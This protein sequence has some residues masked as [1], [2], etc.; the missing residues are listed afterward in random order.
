M[1]CIIYLRVSTKEQAQTNEKEGYSISAQRKACISY[2]RNEGWEV[3]DEYVDRGESARS[4]DRPQL[5]EML[6]RIK[7]EK[8]IDAVV[9]HKLDRFSRNVEE[10]HVIRGE[11][12]RAN[13]QLISV[14]E[15]IEDTAQGRFM[16]SIYASMAQFYSDNLGAEVTKGMYEKVKQGGWPHQAPIGYKNV[17]EGTRNIAIV[18]PDPE[19]A[20]YVKQAFKL[21][22]TGN[23]SFD[24]I[25]D[26]L[27][28]KGV[29]SRHCQSGY[30]SQDTIRKML[31]NP[32]YIGM[33]RYKG[34]DYPGE[35]K[36]IIPKNLYLKVQDQINSRQS[37]IKQR[38][39]PHYLKGSLYC[40]HCGGRL[41]YILAKGKYPYF[42]CLRQYKSKGKECQAKYID[43]ETVEKAVEVYYRDIE[44]TKQA[45]D[46]LIDRF[47]EELVTKQSSNA[48]EEQFLGKRITKLAD[49]RM[50]TLR[51]YQ[52]GA[53]PL[54]LLKQEQDRIASEMAT[55]EARLETIH[56]QLD[57]LRGVL[58]RAIAIARRCG[59]GYM[60]AKPQR[61]RLFNQAFFEKILVT[62]GKISAEYT[63]LFHAL[64]SKSSNKTSLVGDSGF[65][66]LTPS[67]SSWCSP[68]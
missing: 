41:S 13:C 53:I 49:E 32:F 44:L 47:N 42:Y 58:D 57:Q 20:P 11:L 10:H 14:V 30:F 22:A 59:M 62:E 35:H 12:K 7:K 15:K 52:A 2:V 6:S 65:E 55:C 26:F 67:L 37:G 3:V 31:H 9:V 33:M 16:E 1:K 27:Y 40:G 25:N 17:R 21:Y 8:N 45:A 43:V 68:N 48:M 51:A 34:V 46:D 38:K 28:D 18:V 5:R 50:S 39:H 61:R 60:K 66:P 36:P 54:E 29:R 23:Y 63:D 19:T 56:V 4:A 24:D 64:L